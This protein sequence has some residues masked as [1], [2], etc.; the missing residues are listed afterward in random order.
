MKIFGKRNNKQGVTLVE[1][2]CVIAVFGVVVSLAYPL[3]SSYM[4]TQSGQIKNNAQRL[5][6][7]LIKTFMGEDIHYCKK[8]SLDGDDT[9]YVTSNLGNIVTYTLETNYGVTSLVRRTD[10]GK[11]NVFGEVEDVVFE[12]PSSRLVKTELLVD[13]TN[14]VSYDF[15]TSKWGYRKTL[16]DFLELEGV[17][18]YSDSIAYNGS[19]IVAEANSLYVDGDLDTTDRDL[20]GGAFGNVQNI[21]IN[22]DLTSSYG[23]T[24]GNASIDSRIFISGD[25]YL[26]GGAIFNGTIYVTGNFVQSHGGTINGN[27]YVG[28]NVTLSGGPTIN[29]KI[30]YAGNLYKPTWMNV[31]TVTCNPYIEIPTFPIYDMLKLKPKSWFENSEYTILSGGQ[32]HYIQTGDRIYVD[33]TANLL[34][35][36]TGQWAP[37]TPENVIIAGTG[38]VT[39]NGQGNGNL[40]GLIFAPNGSINF[41]NF[42]IFTGVMLS[43]D[44]ICWPRG[45]SYIIGQTL[46]DII[47]NPAQYP[48]EE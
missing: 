36:N 22:G 42:N 18:M 4:K 9:L 47:P 34:I 16:L 12:L 7:E 45:G 38:D 26:D 14:S 27:M 15:D 28:G 24:L 41:N 46:G 25:L 37:L 19:A 17:F 5:D 10:D 31:P 33:G 40:K 11:K 48:F 43:D 8:M 6:V 44:S 35:D 21:Y 23:V 1:L 2:I 32:T 13:T 20:N 3:L 30:M 29:G 39:I